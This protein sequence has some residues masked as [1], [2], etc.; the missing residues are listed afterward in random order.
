VCGA[1]NKSIGIK[2][3]EE[4]MRI[5]GYKKHVDWDSW[6]DSRDLT[7]TPV[8]C[9]SQNDK[10]TGKLDIGSSLSKIVGDHKNAEKIGTHFRSSTT[11]SYKKCILDLS[12]NFSQEIINM[13]LTAIEKHDQNNFDESIKLNE[14]YKYDEETGKRYVYGKK[15]LRIVGKYEFKWFAHCKVVEMWI[16]DVKMQITK[17]KQ[18]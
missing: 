7:K 14:I 13:A 17:Q 1:C 11:N 9:E 18:N 2:N 4:F 10:E 5:H 8:S 6:T 3:M 12:P 16:D 15:V